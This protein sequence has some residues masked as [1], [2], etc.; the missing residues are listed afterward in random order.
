MSRR[1]AKSESIELV[2]F[3]EKTQVNSKPTG[4]SQGST[5]TKQ[6]L[7]STVAEEM[8]VHPHDV[9]HVIQTFLN[10]MTTHLQEGDRLEFRDFGVFEVVKRK[11]KIGRNPKQADVPIVIPSY[12]TVKFTPGKRMRQLVNKAGDAKESLENDVVE[13]KVSF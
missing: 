4:K 3:E 12:F 2:G 13:V 7:I 6:K 8:G 11:P 5:T 9:R 1:K 10:K